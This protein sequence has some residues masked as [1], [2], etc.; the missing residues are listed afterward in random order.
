MRS[1]V[2]AAGVAAG[3]DVV[4]RGV[5]QVRDG[6]PVRRVEPATGGLRIELAEGATPLWLLAL[7]A[8]FHPEPIGEVIVGPFQPDACF[9][10][11]EIERLVV[12]FHEIESVIRHRTDECIVEA[13]GALL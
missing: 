5:Q 1:A 2:R 11:M 9:K 4:V 6:A 8:E 12:D 10:D 7:N 3:E 13:P